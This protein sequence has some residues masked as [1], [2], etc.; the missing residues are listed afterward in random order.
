M[1]SSTFSFIQPP[2]NA[3]TMSS[4]D[5]IPTKER[6]S[7]TGT[8]VTRLRFIK[9]CISR[10]VLS[11]EAVN[12]DEVITSFT[13]SLKS[14][15]RIASE[16]ESVF[17]GIVLILKVYNRFAKKNSLTGRIFVNKRYNSES[18]VLVFHY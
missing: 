1:W 11:G 17:T 2:S 6:P 12:T 8:P 4:I 7:T 14:S 13:L 9:S 10:I 18:S 16:E 15:S 5:M 3:F